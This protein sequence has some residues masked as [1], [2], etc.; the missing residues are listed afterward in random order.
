MK[1]VHVH[2]ILSEDGVALQ[3][4]IIPMDVG[5]ELMDVFHKVQGAYLNTVDS[6]SY[7][8]VQ[9]TVGG[10]TQRLKQRSFKPFIVGLS[11]TAPT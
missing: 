8:E 5:Y 1:N 9:L 3:D 7:T 11:P 6:Y 4:L 10:V 2:D